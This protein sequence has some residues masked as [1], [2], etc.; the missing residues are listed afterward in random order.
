MKIARPI[1][2][3]NLYICSP[4]VLIIDEKDYVNKFIY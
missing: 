3:M 2:E 4:Y 1:L